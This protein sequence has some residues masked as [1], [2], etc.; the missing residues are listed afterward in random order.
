MTLGDMGKAV[1]DSVIR[2]R[3]DHKLH[4]R[5]CLFLFVHKCI[6]PQQDHLG[7]R[8]PKGWGWEQCFLWAQLG[9][10]AQRK[11]ETWGIP[12]PSQQGRFSGEESSPGAI[13][14]IELY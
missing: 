4:L 3:A 2:D 14:A 8:Q 10:G 11:G 7:P 5:N 9:A 1:C 12:I 13:P 6:P